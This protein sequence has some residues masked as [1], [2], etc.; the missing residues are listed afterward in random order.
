MIL[1]LEILFWLMAAILAY[2]Y[3]GYPLLVY[4]GGRIMQATVDKRSQQPSVSI[5]IAA[6]NEAAHIGATLENKLALDY[7]GDRLQIIVVSDGSTDGTDAIVAGFAARGVIGLRQEPRNGKTSALNLALA[8]ATGEVIV[9]ADANSLY[10]PESLRHLI[11]NFA[12]PRVGYVT[13]TLGYVN[14]DGTMTGDGCSLYMRYENFIRTSE[15]QLGSVVGV[16]G[17]IDAVRRSLFQPMK[18]D[19]LP[20]LVL[21][22]RVIAQGYRV[23]Y[24]PAAILSETANASRADEYKMRVRVSLRA[25]WTLA[26]MPDMLSVPRH[27]FYAIQLISHKALRY[28]A[29]VFMIGTFA[30]AL[31]L[32][33]HG[34]VY[35]AAFIA[36][37]AFALGAALGFVAE[38]HGWHNRALSIPYYFVLVN[39]A[40]S[41]ACVKFI[42]GQRSRTWQPRI[43]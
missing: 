27:G 26:E 32:A 20:D 13:G 38:R 23:V 1:L 35:A 10:A 33:P 28:L 3:V 9:F 14:Q 29:F 43:G 30:T 34:P 42:T 7:P 39:A 31:L 17:G 25:L 2:V 36:Q 22:L 19:D 11:R 24:E 41:A 5:L 21:P 16:N 37:M 40:A 12:D 4:V 6:Y 15:T 18:A 8:H